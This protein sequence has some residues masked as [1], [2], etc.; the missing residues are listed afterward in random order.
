MLPDVPYDDVVPAGIGI[1]VGADD[2]Q[3]IGCQRFREWLTKETF[4]TFLRW[5]PTLRFLAAVTYEDAF[6]ESHA[7]QFGGF[8]DQHSRT[9]RG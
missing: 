4:D 1:I 9:F 5:E 7:A 6:G 2:T 8:F 3:I